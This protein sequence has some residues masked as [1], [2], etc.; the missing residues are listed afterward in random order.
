MPNADTV[1]ICSYED[2]KAAV[3]RAAQLLQSAKGS[4]EDREFEML[5]EAIAEFDILQEAQAPVEIPPAFMQFI[6]EAGR[7]RA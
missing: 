7:Q 4:D 1:V 5:T 2:R 3:L 6:R